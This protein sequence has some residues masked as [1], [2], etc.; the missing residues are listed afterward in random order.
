[1]TDSS[2]NWAEVL[3]EAIALTRDLKTHAEAKAKFAA[4]KEDLAGENPELL[5]L[6]TL[7]WEECISAQRGSAFWKEMSDAEKALADDAMKQS[8]QSKQS[9]MRL[10]Q[11]M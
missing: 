9:Y 10:I 8:I 1:M 2:Q 3:N 11:E 7:L 4:L 6:L 5:A